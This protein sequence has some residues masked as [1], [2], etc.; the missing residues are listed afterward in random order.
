MGKQND[1]LTQR[2]KGDFHRWILDWDAVSDSNQM[3]SALTDCTDPLPRDYCSQFDL[4]DGST[5]RDAAELFG[6]KWIS[7]GD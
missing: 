3:L 5:Y 2:L 4:P 7:T 1:Q 6:D